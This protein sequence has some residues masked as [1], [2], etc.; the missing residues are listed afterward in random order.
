[1]VI[2]LATVFCLIFWQVPRS[3]DF[4]LAAALR[5]WRDLHRSNETL[6]AR[7][8]YFYWNPWAA[9]NVFNGGYQL[10]QALI[11]FGRGEWFRRRTR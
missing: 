8:I 2:L 6:C 10:T 7:K 11:A 5:G 1:M 3:R 4:F 9:E